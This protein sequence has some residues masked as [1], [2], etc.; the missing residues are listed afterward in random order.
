MDGKDLVFAEDDLMTFNVLQIG[1][2][3]TDLTSTN[4]D[5]FLFHITK[6]GSFTRLHVEALQ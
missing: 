3:V 4:G 1:A 2:G 6:I 5:D